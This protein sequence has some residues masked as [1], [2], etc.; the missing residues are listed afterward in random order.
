MTH[1]EV[2]RSSPLDDSVQSVSSVLFGLLRRLPVSWL[3]NVA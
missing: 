1:G 2:E 3:P